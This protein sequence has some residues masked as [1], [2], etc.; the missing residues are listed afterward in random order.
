MQGQHHQHA[1]PGDQQAAVI[2]P[3]GIDHGDDQ[4][5]DHV[6]DDRQGQ[7]EDANAAGD[8]AAQQGENPDGEG[9]VGGGGNRPAVAE[10]CLLIE[11][12]VD[13][14]RHQHAAE[15]RDHRQGGLA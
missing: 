4:H 11:G 13:Q 3:A 2:Q 7:Q 15:G 10:R 8:A 12:Q 1:E 6:V 14:R 5:G 9:D